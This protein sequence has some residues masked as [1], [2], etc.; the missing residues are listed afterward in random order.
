MAVLGGLVACANEPVQA[1]DASLPLPPAPP[2]RPHAQRQAPR[3]P[4][5]NG[6]VAMAAAATTPSQADTTE[7]AAIPVSAPAAPIW[8]VRRDGIVGCADR[9]A[10]AMLDDGA[11][12]TPRLL[13]EARASGGCRTTFRMNEWVAEANENDAVLLRLTNGAALTLWFRRSELVAP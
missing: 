7:L 6:E 13:A 8:R 2:P 11:E 12:R 9:A 10:L 3:P 1:P 5:V 4:V